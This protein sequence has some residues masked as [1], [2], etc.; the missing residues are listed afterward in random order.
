MLIFLDFVT[1]VAIG[2]FSLRIWLHV[3]SQTSQIPDARAREINRQV[4]I[5]LLA[6]A[7]TPLVL[8]ICPM[9]YRR[10]STY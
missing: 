6:Q 3:R 8:I 10:P 5:A 2:Y 9:V 7:L 1:Y 4:S